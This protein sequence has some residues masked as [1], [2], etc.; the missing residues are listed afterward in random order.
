MR[1]SL[2]SFGRRLEKPCQVGPRE[3]NRAYNAASL[4]GQKVN[5]VQILYFSPTNCWP[6]HAGRPLRDYHLTKQLA[7][8]ASVTYFG[9]LDNQDKQ[10]KTN[11][12]DSDVFVSKFRRVVLVRKEPSYTFAKLSRGLFGKTPLTVL[13]YQSV[14]V[15]ERLSQLLNE[16]R[17]DSVQIEG[18]HLTPYLPL[19]RSSGGRPAIVCDWHNIES[20]V[21]RMYSRHASWPHR[22]Y[23]LR[24]ASLLEDLERQLLQE[25]DI[26]IVVS[27]KEQAQLK[28][29]S[30]DACIHVIENGVD[31]EHYS[32][33]EL[34]RSAQQSSMRPSEPRKN[35]IFVGSM[36]FHANV[37]GAQ[38]F[39]HKVWP[40]IKR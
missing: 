3:G 40:T 34:D 38:Y 20:G 9:I 11:T 7:R 18:I 24:T 26:H 15:A 30:P 16:V 17:F 13:N 10:S 2:A 22:L 28:R 1:A 12:N 6:L 5:P 19:I 4:G 25:C 33:E 39:A 29:L 21:M 27:S 37:D 23:A 35:V 31:V 36:D 32:D 8:R 14:R